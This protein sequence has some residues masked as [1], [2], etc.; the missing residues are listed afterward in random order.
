[1]EEPAKG[2]L[3]CSVAALSA[4]GKLLLARFHHV[5]NIE[6]LLDGMLTVRVVTSHVKGRRLLLICI[7]V[8]SGF[9]SPKMLSDMLHMRDKCEVHSPL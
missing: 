4:G 5:A 7:P 1:M 8:F 3:N 6:D 9:P 2:R